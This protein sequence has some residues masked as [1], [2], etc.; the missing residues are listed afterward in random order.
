MESVILPAGFFFGVWFVYC[1]VQCRV[2]PVRRGGVFVWLPGRH[3]TLYTNLK[4]RMKRGPLRRPANNAEGRG[5]MLAENRRWET[6][7]QP[8]LGSWIFL[9]PQIMTRGKIAE[10]PRDS[11][12]KGIF[13][14]LKIGRFQ[15]Y[16]ENC[17]WIGFQ[18]NRNDIISKWNLTDGDGTR[19]GLDV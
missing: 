10:Y 12:L 3:Q 19:D 4:T 17:I 18:G 11:G 2:T 15:W 16:H 7:F 13:G 8:N 1:T 5:M 6:I 14:N 9:A